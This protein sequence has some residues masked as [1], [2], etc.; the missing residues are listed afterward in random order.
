MTK[1]VVNLNAQLL[2]FMSFEKLDFFAFRS[3]SFNC[4]KRPLQHEMNAVYAI[5]PLP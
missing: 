2:A 5:S 3:I 1:I 4:S